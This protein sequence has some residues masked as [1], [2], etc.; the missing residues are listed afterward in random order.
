MSSIK[1]FDNV[2]NT[3]MNACKAHPRVNSVSTGNAWEISPAGNVVY[4]LV[5]VVPTS[6]DALD[7]QVKYNFNLIC[8]DLV[9]PGESNEQRVLSDTCST[10]LEIIALFKRGLNR[11]TDS[12]TSNNY[13]D[14]TNEI[15]ETFSLEPFTE[16]FTDNVSGW[17][18][19]FSL[20]M[21]Y[22]YSACM[23][24]AF[25]DITD[26]TGTTNAVT[27]TTINKE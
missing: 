27:A 3:I 18:M 24:D 11:G 9:E 15:T 7:K 22:D 5:M 17:N 19:P 21:R 26:T 23:T 1:T 14:Y 20:T 8:M 6:V 10:L 2:V 13:Y 16:N 25:I 12:I 4:P